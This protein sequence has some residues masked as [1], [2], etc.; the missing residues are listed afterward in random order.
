[1]IKQILL[2]ACVTLGGCTTQLSTQPD[3]TRSTVTQA[4]PGASYALPMLQYDVKLAYKLQRCPNDKDGNADL[5]V[6]VETTATPSYVAG[7][8]YLIDY[9]ALTNKLKI[10]DFTIET[11]ASTGTLKGVNAAAE[12]KTG[13]VIK[14]VTETAI[15]GASI[16]AGSPFAAMQNDDPAQK[17]VDAIVAASTSPTLNVVCNGETLASVKEREAAIDRIKEIGDL[18]KANTRKAELIGLRGS[19][20][21]PNEGDSAALVTLRE[22]QFDLSDELAEKQ[23]QVDT[24]DKS[25]A[26]EDHW[27]WPLNSTATRGAQALTPR[28]IAWTSKLLQAEEVEAIDP[29]KLASAIKNLPQGTQAQKDLKANLELVLR[30]LPP[31]FCATSDWNGC[32]AAHIGVYASLETGVSAVA[33]CVPPSAAPSSEEYKAQFAKCPIVDT[34]AA[35]AAPGIFVREPVKARL[36]L[37]GRSKPCFGTADKPLF[38][39]PL[40]TAPQLGQL[41]FV[42]L[43]NGAFQNNALVVVMATDGTIEKLQYAQ[44]SAI[45]ATALASVSA[46][47]AKIDSYLAK[48]RDN[49]EAE[50]KASRDAITAARTEAAAVRSDDLVKLQAQID[51]LT[52]Q[53]TL[54]DLQNPADPIVAKQYADETI[55]LKAELDRLVTQLAIKDAEAKLAK[56]NSGV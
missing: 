14:A 12:D 33:P 35:D 40:A 31:V 6:Q 55:R 15:S 49:E 20:K 7:E 21:I 43:T 50:A 39:G 32:L 29:I 28:T 52:K 8:R 3:L 13:D 34:A 24:I 42:R 1:M 5:A 17:A 26:F 47:T 4:L 36:V 44:K 53:K 27:V 2:L 16:L 11:H 19:L 48:S 25:L 38:E 30:D 41:R 54:L 37:C 22:E 10:T 45:M 56:A 9:R 51:T 23:A 18:L 46:N